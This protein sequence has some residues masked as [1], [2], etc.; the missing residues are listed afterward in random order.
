MEQNDQALERALAGLD[1]ILERALAAIIL[2]LRRIAPIHE[3][4]RDYERLNLH[5]DTRAA[6]VNAIAL[7]DARVA[8]LELARE[9][10]EA[11]L[12][13]GEIV[14][15]AELATTFARVRYEPIK[16]PPVTQA[17]YDDLAD[18]QRTITAAFG[19]FEVGDEP[20]AEAE[21]IEIEWGTPE[22]QPTAQE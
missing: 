19:E 9:V 13:L 7:Y 12:G 15:T 6:V 14:P 21:R 17:V 20:E 3:G 2:E 11:L 16:L 18:N 22:D 1:G 10:L 5:D 8:L 4:L